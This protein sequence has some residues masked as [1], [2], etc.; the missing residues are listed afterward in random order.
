MQANV[1]ASKEPSAAKA[2]LSSHWL[3]RR[4]PY[5]ADAQE[6]APKQKSGLSAEQDVET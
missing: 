6:S 5:S 1:G 3:A 2:W 4:K